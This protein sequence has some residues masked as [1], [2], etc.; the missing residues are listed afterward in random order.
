LNN[1]TTNTQPQ[2]FSKITRSPSIPG[3]IWETSGWVVP[4][5]RKKNLREDFQIKTYRNL[6]K[7]FSDDDLGKFQLNFG[8][9][10][11]GFSG[12]IKIISTNGAMQLFV[13]FAQ[14]KNE[15]NKI[16]A[17]FAVIA[18]WLTDIA[19]VA[20]PYFNLTIEY[21]LVEN[22]KTVRCFLEGKA[23]SK[24]RL[25]RTRIGLEKN[26][27]PND[28]ICF[29]KKTGASI[30]LEDGKA[31]GNPPCRITSSNI[32]NLG[33][34][35]GLLDE[36]AGVSDRFDSWLEKKRIRMKAIMA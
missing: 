3:I 24:A 26:E 4:I 27:E 13:P 23:S 2:L 1:L 19:P 35:F 7:K 14:D 29:C 11:L 28:L 15:A 30:M 22:Q 16:I 31:T 18:K 9:G 25:I 20:N 21:E 8:K 33:E 6:S 17:S 32:E 36:L 12:S 10:C 5:F 34:V